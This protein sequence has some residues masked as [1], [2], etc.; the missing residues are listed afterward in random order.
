MFRKDIFF[1]RQCYLIGQYDYE[2]MIPMKMI[3]KEGFS[4]VHT[5]L[6]DYREHVLQTSRLG[7]RWDT[8]V[9]SIGYN[10]DE[11][12]RI[13]GRWSYGY[14]SNR[15]LKEEVRCRIYD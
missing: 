1:K 9:S 4:Y 11:F 14:S 15:E 7:K 10:P 12:E 6:Y 13:S 8:I 5:P 3:D 2:V